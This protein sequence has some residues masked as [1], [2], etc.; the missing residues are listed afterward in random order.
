[1]RTSGLTHR[2]SSAGLLLPQTQ[3]GAQPLLHRLAFGFDP[4]GLQRRGHQFVVNHNGGSHRRHPVMNRSHNDSPLCSR[5]CQC[6][7]GDDF[8]A[9]DMQRSTTVQRDLKATAQHHE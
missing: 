1:M 3:Q 2:P 5:K 4:G 9:L 7:R 8:V 6:V